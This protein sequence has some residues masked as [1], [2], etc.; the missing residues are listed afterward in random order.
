MKKY[1]KKVFVRV[2]I[3]LVVIIAKEE[4]KIE[5]VEFLER[6]LKKSQEV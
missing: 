6:Y 5:I 4:E 2:Y 1:K 3:I